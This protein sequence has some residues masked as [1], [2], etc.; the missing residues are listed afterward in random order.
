MAGQ[1]QHRQWAQCDL[2]FGFLQDSRAKVDNP[3]QSSA[4]CHDLPSET[5][6][7]SHL[8]QHVFHIS[9]HHASAVF[10]LAWLAQILR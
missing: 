9:S 4:G 8:L 5:V 10:M 2:A 3:E 1:Q 6:N 7:S